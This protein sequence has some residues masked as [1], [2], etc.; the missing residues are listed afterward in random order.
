MLSSAQLLLLLLLSLSLSQWLARPYA[1]V[2]NEPQLAKVV[3]GWQGLSGA[4]GE[5]ST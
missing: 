2:A 3:N 4:N 5:R 1:W